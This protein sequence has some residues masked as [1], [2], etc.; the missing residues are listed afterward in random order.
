MDAIQQREE[1]EEEEWDEEGYEDEEDDADAEAEAEA[2]ARKLGEELLAGIA[3]V[4]ADQASRFALAQS[5]LS[6][7]SSIPE[8]SAGPA[9]NEAPLSAK[10]EAAITTIRN[11]LNILEVDQLAKSTFAAT[12]LP[13]ASGTNVFD[14][15]KQI[16]G[17]G[18]VAKELA[19]VLS[20]V[21]MTLAA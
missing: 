5:L 18:S 16:S 20:Q 2:I 6:A 19:G 10:V 4:Q 17:A 14:V 21:V 13:D 8:P 15:L 12:L 7:Q 9:A 1:E 3:K 11:I